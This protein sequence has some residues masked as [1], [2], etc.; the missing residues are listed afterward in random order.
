MY[1]KN[2]DKYIN[3]EQMVYVPQVSFGVKLFKPRMFEN[4][5]CKSDTSKEAQKTI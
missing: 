1:L 2:K 4:N 3:I 5:I